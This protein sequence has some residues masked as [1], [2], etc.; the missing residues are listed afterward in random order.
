MWTAAKL[1]AV[2]TLAAK[3]QELLDRLG[4]GQLAAAVHLL[5]TFLD[6]DGDTLSPAKAK[7]IAKAGF[8][9]VTHRPRFVR[10]RLRLVAGAAFKA[11]FDAACR[12]SII[13][14]TYATRSAMAPQ[15]RIVLRN[16]PVPFTHPPNSFCFLRSRLL[17]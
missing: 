15:Y 8:P 5:E 4:P 12:G 2:N 13:L 3:A 6:E 16:P 1:T 7:A 14:T 11:S 10:S 9:K 17:H